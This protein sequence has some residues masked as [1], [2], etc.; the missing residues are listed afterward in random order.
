[1]A[2]MDAPLLSSSAHA[3]KIQRQF[4][5]FPFTRL[6]WYRHESSFS[7]FL[8]GQRLHR[9]VHLVSMETGSQSRVKYAELVGRGLIITFADGK[10]ALFPADLLYSTLPQAEEL[11]ELDDAE[12][13]S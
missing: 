7:V 2:G 13:S 1:M 9:F 11:N 4:A 10:C 12:P 5:E 3:E 8:L 6:C